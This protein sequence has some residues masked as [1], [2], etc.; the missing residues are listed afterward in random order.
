M[1]CWQKNINNMKKSLLLFIVWVI[2][3]SVLA[4]HSGNNVLSLK[5]NEPYVSYNN[6]SVILPSDRIPSDFLGCTLGVTTEIDALKKLNKLGIPF[7]S[8]EDGGVGDVL[9]IRGDIE[10]EGAKF[11]GLS[12]CFHNNLFWKVIFYNMKTDSK[13]L[14]NTIKQKYSKFLKINDKYGYVRYRGK[15]ADL[16]HNDY[17]LQYIIRGGSA[18]QW[19]DE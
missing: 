14:V 13:V 9:S 17:C 16:V 2:S 1:G 10:C 6:R 3:S 4:Q 11:M 5:F 15:S 18:T 12:L 8:D 19:D 7:E